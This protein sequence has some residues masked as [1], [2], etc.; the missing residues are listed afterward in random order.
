MLGT[1]MGFVAFSED[2][3]GGCV[4]GGAE[5]LA[6]MISVRGAEIGGDWRLGPAIGASVG[7][8]GPSGIVMGALSGAAGGDGIEGTGLLEGSSPVG[9]DV[10]MPLGEIVSTGCSPCIVLI[11][12]DVDMSWLLR[13]IRIKPLYQYRDK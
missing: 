8:G 13:F 9:N 1:G 7:G 10:S 5:G 4:V 12:E 11:G 6:S 2:W 3:D